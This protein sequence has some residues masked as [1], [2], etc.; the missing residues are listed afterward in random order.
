MLV[1]PCND[2]ARIRGSAPIWNECGSS[3]YSFL[4]ES[5]GGI[6]GGDLFGDRHGF[7]IRFQVGARRVATQ[8]RFEGSSG[9]APSP[10]APKSRKHPH[11]R[12]QGSVY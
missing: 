12:L 1:C 11:E 6:P 8:S 10:P 9:V 7:E 5:S 4:R 3:V 2:A